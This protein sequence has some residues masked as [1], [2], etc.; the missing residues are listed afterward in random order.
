MELSSFSVLDSYSALG[1]DVT[2]RYEQ[3][4]EL[5]TASERHGLLGTWA[6]EHHFQAGG[7]C[8]SPPVLLA[9]A[10]QRT[11]RLKLGSMVGVLPLHDPIHLAEEYALLDRLSN[12]RLRFGVGS[13]YIPLEFSGFGIDPFRKRE[14]FD[15]SLSV[16]LAA[17]SGDAVPGSRP[18]SERV[19]LN[20]LPIQRPHPPVWVAAQRSEAIPHIGSRGHSVA[21]LPYA[22]AADISD[23][24]RIVREYRGALRRGSSGQVAAVVHIFCGREVDRARRALQRYLDS[25][26]AVREAFLRDGERVAPHRVR[27]ET[28]M[29]RGFALFGGQRVIEE[30]LEAFR[31]IGVDEVLGNFDF[32]GLRSAQV[33]YSVGRAA[34]A[35]GGSPRADATRLP[36]A[37]ETPGSPCPVGAS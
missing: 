29:D 20:V 13:G 30:G 21:L 12:G 17:M 5:A 35:L 27:A 11:R 31:R 7:V 16:V 15:R 33:R 3:F 22:T 36:D 28:L 32:G 25:R 18:E 1:A 34:E 6:A 10:S 19:R 26:M 24:G 8:P 4:L 2:A 9:A 14:L 23:L 37:R